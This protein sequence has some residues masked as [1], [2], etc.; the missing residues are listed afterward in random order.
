MDPTHQCMQQIYGIY[1][2][3]ANSSRHKNL[4]RTNTE[5]ILIPQDGER[6]VFYFT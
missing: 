6:K 4:P 5:K 3:K 2:G 1:E